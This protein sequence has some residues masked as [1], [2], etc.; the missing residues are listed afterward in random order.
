[1]DIPEELCAPIHQSA[2][3]PKLWLGCNPAA[4]GA[5]TMMCVA[6]G[7]A[8]FS[9]IGT[10]AVTGVFLL[11]REALR[12]MAKEDPL[13]FAVYRKSKLYSQGFWTA[14]PKRAKRWRL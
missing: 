14:K 7:F 9:F 10:L 13:Y 6:M 11:L 1:M 8:L 5:L 4:I 3:R 12:E 2:N